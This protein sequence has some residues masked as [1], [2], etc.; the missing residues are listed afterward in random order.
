MEKYAM[1][2]ANGDG[3]V[4]SEELVMMTF[5][6][7]FPDSFQSVLTVRCHKVSTVHGQPNSVG[8]DRSSAPF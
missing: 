1:Y 5:K 6:N 7:L 3:E 4:T 2:D 8:S